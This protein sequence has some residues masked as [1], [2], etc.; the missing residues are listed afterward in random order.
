MIDTPRTNSYIEIFPGSRREP[1]LLDFAR[2]LER[3]FAE[4][5]AEIERKGSLIEQ[6]REEISTAL[7]HLSTNYS[8]DGGTMAD[9]DA[10]MHLR[11]ALK[12]AERGE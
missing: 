6:M 5:R 2:Q 12:A 9:S 1:R 7:M 3:E 4:A 11:A 10:A 8:I